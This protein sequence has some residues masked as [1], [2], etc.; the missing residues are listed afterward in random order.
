MPHWWPLWSWDGL[1]EWLIRPIT[2]STARDLSGQVPRN[3]MCYFY[4]Y[5][6]KIIKSVIEILDTIQLL[7]QLK[8]HWLRLGRRSM[9]AAWWRLKW[10]CRWTRCEWPCALCTPLPRSPSSK[11][12]SFYFYS[13]NHL[14]SKETSIHTQRE[15]IA[16]IHKY[17]DP[18]YFTVTGCRRVCTLFLILRCN[19]IFGKLTKN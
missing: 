13:S 9:W 4:Y 6:F 10:M 14:L 8:A 1:V 16:Y 19:S 11:R 17:K 7:T 18:R 12:S 15:R 5:Y 2:W 3:S